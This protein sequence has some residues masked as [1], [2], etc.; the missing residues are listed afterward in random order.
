MIYSS[1]ETGKNE[2]MQTM[3]QSLIKLIDEGRI[4]MEMGLASAK[5]PDLLKQ[6]LSTRRILSEQL[7]WGK[8]E[9]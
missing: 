7:S 1:I 4:T 6:R 5:N 2:G 3:E 9:D 8:I